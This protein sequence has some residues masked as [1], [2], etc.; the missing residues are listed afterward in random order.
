MMGCN[1]VYR[2]S[3]S[4][5]ANPPRAMYEGVRRNGARIARAAELSSAAAEEQ[6]FQG[7][8]EDVDVETDGDVL[9]VE[10]VVG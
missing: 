10:E 4:A 9:D 5:L 6:D 1:A 7:G 2:T 8:E 3:T